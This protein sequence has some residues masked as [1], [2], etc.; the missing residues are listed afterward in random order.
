MHIAFIARDVS[1]Y[2]MNTSFKARAAKDKEWDK[3]WQQNVWGDTIVQGSD[4]VSWVAVKAGKYINLRKLFGICVGKISELQDGDER[5][6]YKHRAVFQG[7]RAVDQNMNDAQF[8]DS[9]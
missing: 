8:Q 2:E 6:K 1:K 9:G 3:L 7:N 5:K 4:T